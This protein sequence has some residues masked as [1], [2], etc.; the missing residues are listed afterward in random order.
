MFMDELAE[1][2]FAQFLVGYCRGEG[3]GW[4]PVAALFESDRVS[5]SWIA[6]SYKWRISSSFVCVC[7]GGSFPLLIHKGKKK[8]L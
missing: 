6:R 8:F 7:G 3:E 1:V 2:E 4:F 5:R